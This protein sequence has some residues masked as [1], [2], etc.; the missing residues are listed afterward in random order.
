[1]EEKEFKKGV[2]KKTFFFATRLPFKWF[3]IKFST[4]VFFSNACAH[5]FSRVAFSLHRATH[6]RA[7]SIH[8]KLTICHSS[9]TFHTCQVINNR[10]PS[11]NEKNTRRIKKW[12]IKQN[13]KIS[14]I[15]FLPSDLG[16]LRTNKMT[17]LTFRSKQT[18]TDIFRR[19]IRGPIYH[20]FHIFKSSPSW[21]FS[22]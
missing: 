13:R 7:R 11:K 19:K 2:P 4:F 14:T 9:A 12:I 5:S 16:W 10:G 8:S 15:F 18:F 20:E 21:I 3:I 1:M 6:N 17:V 22:D